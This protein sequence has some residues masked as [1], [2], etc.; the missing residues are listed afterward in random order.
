MQLRRFGMAFFAAV[1]LLSTPV[2]AQLDTYYQ[3]H[4]F[5]NIGLGTGNVINMTNTGANINAAFAPLYAPGSLS[6]TG[7]NTVYGSGYICVNAYVFSRDEQ[8][9]SCCSCLMSPDSHWSWNVDLDMAAPG[10]TLTGVAI[11]EVTVKLIT[12]ASSRGFVCDATTAGQPISYTPS[13]TNNGLPLVPSSFAENSVLSPGLLA[14]GRNA[15]NS[16]LSFSNG[17]LSMSNQ[18][19]LIGAAAP[20]SELTRDAELCEANTINGSGFG[21]CK[22]CRFGGI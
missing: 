5:E 17:T 14:F 15:F 20:P 7:P 1:L 6:P 13:N 3:L 19:G 2:F 22:A 8:L 9:Q 4:T 12:T 16:E 18:V 21:V 11:N 10:V